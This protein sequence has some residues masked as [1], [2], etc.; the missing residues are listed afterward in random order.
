MSGTRRNLAWGALVCA[1]ATT[2][3]VFPA[4]IAATSSGMVVENVQVVPVDPAT[5]WASLVGEVNRWWPRD[6][7]W[8]GSESQLSLDATAGGCFCE[9]AGTRQAKHLEVAF[10]DPPAHLRML[11]GLGPFQ[12]MGLHGAL[13]WRLESVEGG[14][15]ISFRYQVGGYTP[16]D[17]GKIAPIV[18]QVQALQLGG[19]ADYL[20]ASAARAQP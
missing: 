18:D 10:V 6:H 5:A 11:G 2:P 7:T 9:V 13:D 8:W 1:L 16:D 15:R 17:V 12:G 14:T 20:R 19:L 3:P 4:V